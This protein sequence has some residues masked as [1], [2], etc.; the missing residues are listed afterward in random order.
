MYS[1]HRLIRPKYVG[2]VEPSGLV[3][4]PVIELTGADCIL[5]IPLIHHG[6]RPQKLTFTDC[7][8]EQITRLNY[9]LI[10]LSQI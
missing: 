1:Q 4:L 8:I 7:V 6:E 5:R 10:F 3:E 2:M 9:F